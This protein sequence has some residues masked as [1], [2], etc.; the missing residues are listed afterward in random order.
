[1]SFRLFIYYCALCGGWAALLAWALSEFLS[2]RM[3]A[4]GLF[5]S[6]VLGGILGLL[7]SSA[8]G[9]LDVLFN[10]SQGNRPGRILVSIFFGLTGGLAGGILCEVLTMID[11]WLRLLG[12]MIVGM[13]IGLSLGM[14]ELGQAFLTQKG[15]RLVRQKLSNGVLGGAL[16]GITGGLLYTS[17]DIMELKN[18]LPRTS[19]AL[20]LV[21]LGAFIGLFVGWAQIIPGGGNLLSFE[22]RPQPDN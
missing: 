3:M 12:W 21:I 5:Y 11:P 17:L 7:I 18:S 10:A 14:Y 2:L 16:G 6:A 4:S 20:G 19:L 22:K 15:V 1:M 8:V 9:T 13:A